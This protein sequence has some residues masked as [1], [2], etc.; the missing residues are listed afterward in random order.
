MLWQMP[1]RLVPSSQQLPFFENSST[2]KDR[3]EVMM[4]SVFAVW[5]PQWVDS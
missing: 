2:H 3:P 5:P 4:G 1:I